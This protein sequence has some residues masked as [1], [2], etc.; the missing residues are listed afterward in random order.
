MIAV[1]SGYRWSSLSH[2]AWCVPRSML[3]IDERYKETTACIKLDIV[4]FKYE[5]II[6]IF[7]GRPRAGAG[8]LK[9]K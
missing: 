4:R 9:K 7:A 2:N 6:G 5:K 1:H 3:D 8:G